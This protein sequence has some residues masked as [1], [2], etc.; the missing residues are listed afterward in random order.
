MITISASLQGRAKAWFN[1]LTD[2]EMEKYDK[3]M[4]AFDRDIIQKRA[5]KTY[6]KVRQ[7]G[8]RET[9][10]DYATFVKSLYRTGMPLNVID[11][12]RM[13]TFIEGV[14]LPIREE[15]I[16]NEYKDFEDLLRDAI[17]WENLLN[18][19][20]VT[21][22]GKRKMDFDTPEQLSKVQRIQFA[23]NNQQSRPYSRS[24]NTWIRP[25]NQRKSFNVAR[26]P[27]RNDQSRTIDGKPICFTCGKPG[28]IRANCRTNPGGKFENVKPYGRNDMKSRKE[29]FNKVNMAVDNVN[30]QTTQCFVFKGEIDGVPTPIIADTGT[31]ISIIGEEFYNTYM[32][33]R[34]LTEITGRTMAANGVEMNGRGEIN[35]KVT[36]NG[37]TYDQTFRIITEMQKDILI[38]NNFLKKNEAVIDMKN[39]TISLIMT[40]SSKELSWE[41]RLPIC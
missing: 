23:S 33:Q 4:D 16:D 28:H 18:R 10:E 38:G 5:K 17:K 41:T 32:G 24:S 19:G 39:E 20:A 27:Y 29:P 31:G 3:F 35:A 37:R 30:T 21:R 13:R 22:F 25:Q 8:S 2:I 14:L 34:R 15:L 26:R 11:T 1:N 7:Q 36:I 6:T 40:M 9:V 12:L